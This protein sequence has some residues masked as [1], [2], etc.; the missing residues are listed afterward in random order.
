MADDQVQAFLERLQNDPA[1]R[2]RFEEVGDVGA[3]SA[4]VAAGLAREL[5]FAISAADLI[6]H[7]ARLLLEQDDAQLEQTWWRL[8][9]RRG[10]LLIRHHWDSQDAGGGDHEGERRAQ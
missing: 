1:L 8:C 7:Q 3:L 6:R 2:E 10:M 9:G 5:G 4:A